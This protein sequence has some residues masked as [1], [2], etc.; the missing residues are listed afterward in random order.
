MVRIFARFALLT[1]LSCSVFAQSTEKPLTFELAD[2][3]ASPPSTLAALAAMSGGVP[4]GGR[5]EL[6]NASMLDLI[7][8]AYGVE[9]EKVIGGPNWLTS[10]RFDVIA[11]VPAGTTQ[12]KAR[13]MLRTLLAERFGLTVHNDSRPVAVFVL[14]AEIGRASCKES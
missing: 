3:H 11:K 10:D 13:L 6:R 2:I 8:T 1:V 14:S 4:R 7:R 12:E 9:P 5:Y